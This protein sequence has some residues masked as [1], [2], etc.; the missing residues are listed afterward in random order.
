VNLCF[1][2]NAR[3][4]HTWRWTRFFAAK[5]HRVFLLTFHPPEHLDYGPVAVQVFPRHRSQRLLSQVLD[6]PKVLYG[7]KRFIRDAQPDL[8]H[9]H[10]VAGYDWL[11][12]MSGFH[13]YVVTPWGSDVL[14]E[15][16][17][18]QWR[19]LLTKIALRRSDLIT[20]DGHHIKEELVR[21][22]IDE[23][24]IQI[25]YFGTDVGRFTPGQKDLELLDRFS[26]KGRAVVASTRALH[27]VHDVAT[28]LR[29]L[30]AVLS[31]FQ[32]VA[33]VVIGDGPERRNLEELSKALGVSD[34]VRFVGR[35]SEHEMVKWLQTVDIYI[36]TSLSDAGLSAST[37]EAMA[38]GLP[39]I[40]T[41]NAD[42]R[43]WVM[44]GAG[45]FL[46][47][48]STPEALA[49]RLLR[50]LKDE[51]L[52][53]RCGQFNRRVIEERN[54]YSKEMGRME[55]FYEELARRGKGGGRCSWFGDPH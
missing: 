18:S 26:L 37:A 23:R 35:V 10:T 2:A 15:A 40:V 50:L 8:L 1:I 48:N 38:C 11:A 41:D 20:T 14:I 27:A 55:A 52:R 28:A 43:R 45:G 39:V 16:K 51:A 53:Q 5:G 47:P 49:D 42:N 32:D 12:M 22:G 24:K 46:V 29:A 4:E 9:A 44:E 3:S 54:N 25:V 30:P 34:H 36:S 17:R 19:R 21:W 6:L 33:L 7:V 31:Q 13:P